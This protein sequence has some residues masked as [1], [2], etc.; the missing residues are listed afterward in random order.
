[1]HNEADN[2]D[3][4]FDRLVDNE[5]SESERRQLLELLDAQPEGWRRCAL[6][7]LESQSWR[8]EF[9]Q[10]TR[11]PRQAA[12]VIWKTASNRLS[13]KPWT[14]S[15]Q[16]LAIA[17]GLLVAFVLGW[18]QRERDVPTVGP[19]AASSQQV[20]S[21]SAEAPT[22]SPKSASPSDALTLFVRDERGK[23][24]PVHVPLVD[25]NTLDKQLGVKFQTG[26]P[27]MIRNRLQDRGF[28]VQ[29]RQRYAPLWFE[30]DGPPMIV[31]VE[32]TKIVPV[33]DRVY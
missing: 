2:D 33:S 3:I 5:L 19:A 32:D 23:M 26:M 30:K 11:A 29:S 14:A 17:A 28:N 21:T 1:M 31:P 16:W 10:L 8:Q 20:A 24:N 18:S 15:I 27:D 25:A 13:R 6:A 9:S 7:F 4:L 12:D 22:A